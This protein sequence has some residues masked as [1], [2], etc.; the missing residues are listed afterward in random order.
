MMPN[1]RDC[2]GTM[3]A[4]SEMTTLLAWV[5]WFQIVAQ[6]MAIVGSTLFSGALLYRVRFGGLDE[7]SVDLEMIGALS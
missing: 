6:K 4:M 5:Q 1:Y 3:Q 7:S 2:D